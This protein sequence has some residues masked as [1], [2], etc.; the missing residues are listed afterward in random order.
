MKVALGVHLEYSTGV[1]VLIIC[2]EEAIHTAYPWRTRCV[3]PTGRYIL[4]PEEDASRWTGSTGTQSPPC[5]STILPGTDT[6]TNIP[7]HAGRAGRHKALAPAPAPRHPSSGSTSPSPRPRLGAVPRRDGRRDLCRGAAKH[8][9]NTK[10]QNTVMQPRKV[11]S[12]PFLFARRGDDEVCEWEDAVAGSSAGELFRRGHKVS[13]FSQF[14]TMLDII[15]D[16]A[17]DMKGWAICRIEGTT[18]PLERRDQMQLFQSAGDAARV[19]TIEEKIM[20]RATEKRKLEAL[21]IA[22]GKFKMP[23]AADEA[24][25]PGATMAEM[26]ADL[27]RLEGD[28]IDV[29]PPTTRAGDA[30]VL[31]A[32]L[33][34]S[35]KVFADRGTG[36]R[37]A[38]GEGRGVAFAVFEPPADAGSEA[39]TGIMGEEGVDE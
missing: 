30:A 32:L 26:A 29:L 15:E 20:Q 25:V 19:H 9:N 14:T 36:W 8:V 38:E 17:V 4:G 10:L 31:E 34:R 18:P 1:T 21:V 5:P 35:P 24:D 12:H 3:Y 22:K 6:N 16:W 13:L 2:E 11:C 37:S 39:L 23:A 28:Q 27:L 33:D 7:V